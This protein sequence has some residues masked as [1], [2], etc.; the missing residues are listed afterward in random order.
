MAFNIYF[1]RFA[2]RKNSTLRPADSV[3][4]AEIAVTLKDG[5]SDRSPVFLLNYPNT[6]FNFNYC[7]WGTWYYFVDNIV[8]MRNNLIQVS[9]S[10][11]VL[12]TFKS[13]IL[14]TTAFVSYSSVSGGQWLADKR[15]PVKADCTV[16]T[17]SA[18][19]PF[20]QSGG[21]YILS[22]IGSNGAVT[23]YLGLGGLKSLVRNISTE[24]TTLL[25]AVQALDFTTPEKAIESLTT[26]LV[27]TGLA[28]NGYENAPACI[29]SCHWIPFA[30][31]EGSIE[32]TQEIYLGSYATGVTA[33][34]VSARPITGSVAVSIPW[35]YSD[36]RRAYCEDLYLYLP[37]V[38]M[39]Q[40]SA[41]SLTQASS[42]TV[43][44]S[45]T[46]T[47]GVI[48]YMVKAGGEIIGTYGGNCQ[49]SYPIGVNQRTSLGEIAQTFFGGAAKSVA[50]AL[51]PSG[52]LFNAITGA[53]STGYNTIDKALSTHPSCV[54][55]IGG[56]AGAGIAHNI[57]CY[58]V[59]HSTAC[60]TSEMASVMGVPTMKPVTLSNC[61][62]YCECI[63]AH[64]AITAS[65]DIINAIDSFINSGFFIE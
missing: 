5:T 9:C 47:D 51:S 33:S 45:Y 13:Q 29:R 53:V 65:G 2:K 62:G 42:V 18:A 57:V 43:D 38:G 64:A 12:A 63:N 17:A 36:W 52:G 4:T 59:A 60:E 32:G 19:A 58:S 15:I 40:L 23:Y 22:T 1:G 3:F 14:N 25:Q 50:S 49:S 54:G 16:S 39:V 56:G 41:D 6:E 46:L 26:G 35:Q 11:D 24:N 44:Y 61:T 30:I 10:M 37:L 21:Y 34:I 55:G 27:Q 28:G 20:W 31:G 8:Y 48:C 7:K